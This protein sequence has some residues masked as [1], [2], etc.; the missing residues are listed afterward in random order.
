MKTKDKKERKPRAERKTYRN[1]RGYIVVRRSA[2]EMRTMRQ[3]RAG[4]DGA[5]GATVF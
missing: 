5:D 4:A 1:V 3:V 2:E